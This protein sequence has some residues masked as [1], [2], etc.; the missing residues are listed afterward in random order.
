MAVFR[1]HTFDSHASGNCVWFLLCCSA[2]LSRVVEV[3][4]RE[5]LDGSMT[6]VSIKKAFRTFCVT[7][8]S[9]RSSP[10]GVFCCQGRPHC[11]PAG[12]PGGPFLGASRE[13]GS[14]S[15]MLSI[16]KYRKIPIISPWLMFVQKAFLLG[17]F[18]EGLVIG[19]NF[20]FQNGFDL[21]IKNSNSNSP[22]AYIRE[23][24]LSEGYLHLRFG[25][26]IFGRAYYRKD[27]CV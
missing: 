10:T 13:A 7:D 8:E 26:L 12:V 23:G 15:Q 21:S 3:T 9:Q 27:I 16:L 6:F 25:G 2:L 22:W 20:A 24:L 11:A 1:A 17:L 14:T 18:L 19:R 4:P 5:L